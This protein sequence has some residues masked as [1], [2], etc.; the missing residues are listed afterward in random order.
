[1]QEPRRDRS[2]LIWIADTALGTTRAIFITCLGVF[3]ANLRGHKR[4]VMANEEAFLC[5][6]ITQAE[7]RDKPPDK[8]PSHQLCCR[9]R[10][11]FGLCFLR[12]SISD[13]FNASGSARFSTVGT[14][15]NAT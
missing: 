15:Q 7:S 4:F 3:S 1:M 12:S 14:L 5:H 10:Y 13:H 9:G 6:S 8:P 2:C 11:S